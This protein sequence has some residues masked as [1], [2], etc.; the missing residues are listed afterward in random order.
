VGEKVEEE[1]EG[2]EDA[3]SLEAVEKGEEQRRRATKEEGDEGEG[4]QRKRR[5]TKEEGD[6]GGGRTKRRAEE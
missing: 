4:R 3:P 5:A 2:G 1:S 6:E